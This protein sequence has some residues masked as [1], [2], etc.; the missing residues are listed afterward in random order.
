MSDN[1]AFPKISIVI[2]MYNAS[3]SIEE[4]L[5]NVFN[6]EY[7]EFEVILVDDC[8][9]D[10]TVQKVSR[11]PCEFLKNEIN[12][13]PAYSRNRGVKEA[14]ANIILFIDSDVLIPSD[15]LQR[16]FDFFSF[17]KYQFNTAKELALQ[18]FITKTKNITSELNSKDQPLYKKLWFLRPILCLLFFLSVSW[19]IFKQGFIQWFFLI[20]ILISS[21][22]AEF[23][24]R[25]YLFRVAPF[26]I[27]I[28]SFFLYFYDGFLVGLGA[29]VG[30]LQ[31]VYLKSLKR[32]L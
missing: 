3:S 15:M 25:L 22:F 14:K 29:A 10:D 18:Y 2:P 28:C 12:Q 9:S 16:I 6:S 19:L 4:C 23:P 21:F 24:F 8:S 30:L 26:S 11:F 7:R 5:E 32:A 17:S 27:W 13:G 20:S 31:S 1:I